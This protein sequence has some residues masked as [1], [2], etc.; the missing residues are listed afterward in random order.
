M[1][2]YLA[3]MGIVMEHEKKNLSNCATE[4]TNNTNTKTPKIYFVNG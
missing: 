3:V 4:Y 1:F 2:C